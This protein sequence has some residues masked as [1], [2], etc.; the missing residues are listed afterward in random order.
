[1]STE[2][3]QNTADWGKTEVLM[4]TEHRR[5][6]ADW[7]KTEVLMRNVSVLVCPLQNLHGLNWNQTR[8][9]ATSNRKDRDMPTPAIRD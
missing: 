5:N 1:M 7:G 6:A 8:A 2:H 4:S 3:R 9:Y